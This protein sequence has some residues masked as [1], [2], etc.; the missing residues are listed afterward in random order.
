[1]N[2]IVIRSRAGQFQTLYTEDIDLRKIIGP[3]L[4]IERASNVEY[5]NDLQ[6]WTVQFVNGSFL[7]IFPTREAALKAEVECLQR[8]W[9][10]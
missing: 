5:D 4:N 7:G 1:M 9:V 6:G 10:G 3:T 2:R 8:G